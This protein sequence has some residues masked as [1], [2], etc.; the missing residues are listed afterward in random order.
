MVDVLEF[1]E[2][3]WFWYPVVRLFFIEGPA[4]ELLVFL[5]DC[6]E[7]TLSEETEVLVV[8]PWDELSG[9]GFG[10]L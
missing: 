5:F 4:T 3:V 1:L 10:I 9:D 2:S 7:G 8:V 6:D